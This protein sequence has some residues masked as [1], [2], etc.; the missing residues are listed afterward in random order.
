MLI[1][2]PNIASPHVRAFFTTKIFT[3]NHVHVSDAVA[4]EFNI[5]AAKIYLPVQKHTNRIQ[6]LEA[7]TAPEVADAVIT[8]R[9]DVYIGVLVADCVPI[10]LF[11]KDKEAVGAVHAG[12]RGTA[13]QI[14]QETIITMQEKFRSTPEDISI[15]IGPCIRKCSYEVDEDVKDAVERATGQ[16]DYYTGKGNKYFIDLS[17]A[18]RL[19]ALSAGILE[20]NIWQSGECTFCSPEQFYSYRYAVNTGGR[21]GGFIGMW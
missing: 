4:R 15:A 12:W 19:Q 6:I 3:G 5:P 9:K 21:Q 16:G 8:N 2:P 20:Q 1:T 7:D 11:D 18:N 10:L 17:S 13:Q 14:L